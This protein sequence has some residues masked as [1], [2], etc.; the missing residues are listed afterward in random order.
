MVKLNKM[1]GIVGL[2]FFASQMIIAQPI[3]RREFKCDAPISHFSMAKT[4]NIMLAANDNAVDV[5]HVRTNI[6]MRSFKEHQNSVVGVDIQ[7][8][9]NSAASIDESGKVFVWD[10]NSLKIIGKFDVESTATQVFYAPNGEQINVL[11]AD[12]RTIKIYDTKSLELLKTAALDA[13]TPKV[14]IDKDKNIYSINANK[15]AIFSFDN[16]QLTLKNNWKAGKNNIVDIIKS[17]KNIFTADKNMITKWN[18]DF[19]GENLLKTK[20]NITDFAITADEKMMAISVDNRI[21]KVFDT[22]TK[23]EVFTVAEDSNIKAIQFHPTE[24]LALV[25][26]ENGTIKSWIIRY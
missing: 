25:R 21:F 15:I 3:P 18:S 23:K 8:N 5:L 13:P 20:D 24:P 2:L 19:K 1:M 7:P 11:L 9:A 10:I 17:D 22:K 16:Q 12:K 26:L 6:N 4:G 14:L